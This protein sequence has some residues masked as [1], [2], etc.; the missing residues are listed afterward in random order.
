L[1]DVFSADVWTLFMS[2]K[3]E[4]FHL[5]KCIIVWDENVN[6]KKKNESDEF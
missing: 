1:I 4:I 5:S 3:I 2:N 6:V